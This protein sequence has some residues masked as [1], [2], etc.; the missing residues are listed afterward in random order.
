VA[1]RINITLQATGGSTQ[2]IPLLETGKLDLG[3]V[4]GT[5]A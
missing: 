5:T 1:A 3:L 4:E 2:N